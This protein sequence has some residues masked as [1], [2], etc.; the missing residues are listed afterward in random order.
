MPLAVLAC[1]ATPSPGRAQE[2]P[3]T[4][5]VD[6]LAA[7]D[8]LRPDSLALGDS[9]GPPRLGQTPDSASADT[10]FYNLPLMDRGGPAGWAQGIWAWEE[11]AIQASGA[12]TL[13]ELLADVPGVLPLLAGDHGTP[14]GVTAFGVGGGQVRILRDGFEVLPLEGGVAD[15]ARVGLAGISL[16]RLERSAGELIIRMEGLEHTDGRPY[17]VVE[18]A[19]GDQGNNFFRGTFADPVALGGSVGIALERSDARGARGNEP[20]S[21]TGSWLRYQLHRGDAAG[22]A[23]DF[24]RVGSETASADFASPVVRTD[25]TVRGRARLATGVTG[26]AYWGKSTHKVDDDGVVYEREGGSRSQM[27]VRAALERGGLFADGAYRRFGGEDL[28][29][30]RLDLSAGGTDPRVGGFT[31]ELDRAAWP[32]TTT[33]ARR[34]RGWTRPVLGVSVFGSWESGT[35]GAR[36]FP[37]MTPLPGDSLGETPAAPDT[38][39][40]E[41]VFRVTDR[42]AT[43]VGAQW[44][45]RDAAV[46]GARLEMEADSLL[47][48]GIEPDRGEPALGGGTRTGWEIWGRFPTPVEGLR[49]EGSLQQWDE[50]WSYLPRRTY[51]GAFTFHRTYLASGNLE[52]WWTVGVRGHDAMTVRQVVGQ[53]LDDQ[54]EVVGPKLASVP[55][56]QN[57]YARLQLRIVSMRIFVGWENFTVRRDLQ[58]Y[59]DRLLPITR[60]VYGI[61]W[62]LWN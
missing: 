52:W 48:L 17:S 22:L 53:D 13:A 44:V 24:R 3:D 4:I 9:L 10:I 7:A 6:S 20:G 31:A 35:F 12:L 61:R 62:T 55:I 27:G 34:V 36:S 60:A 32:G 49:L 18:A 38:S 45:W 56:Y 51:T 47:P 29:S 25:L 16:V 21:V 42:S 57:W 14:V 2:P 11:E 33:S 59:P 15:L 30:G 23:V 46:S 26:E 41:P 37:V 28:P 40:S 54:G 43:R 8:T 19:T 1:L 58:N 50:P 5:R 39:A